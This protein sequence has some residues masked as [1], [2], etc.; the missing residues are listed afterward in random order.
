MKCNKVEISFIFFFYYDIVMMAITI[1]PFLLI[2]MYC[3]YFIQSVII[4]VIILYVSAQ[5]DGHV[6]SSS[7]NRHC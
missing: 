3:R 7:Q 6:S 2:A 5:V 4:I 1:L